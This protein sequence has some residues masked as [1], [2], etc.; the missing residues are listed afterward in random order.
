MIDNFN[1]FKKP[2][3]FQLI[4]KPGEEKGKFRFFFI[5]LYFFFLN[6]LNIMRSGGQK[7]RLIGNFKTSKKNWLL[8][9]NIQTRRRER[10]IS[11][12]PHFSLFILTDLILC[13]RTDKNKYWWIISRHFRI[14]DYFNQY[15]NPA[16]KKKNFDFSL[17]FF[18]FFN[19]LNIIP[20]GVLQFVLIRNFNTFKKPD[21]FQLI[22]K[23]G[24]E[25]G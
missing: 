25:K 22:S 4:S 17:F 10:N 8:S 7:Y 24:E 13:D 15:L 20:S 21:Y 2:D 14:Y 3:Y 12:S 1:T 5:F 19:Q 11:M 23:P 9:T 16:T 18:I 6:R